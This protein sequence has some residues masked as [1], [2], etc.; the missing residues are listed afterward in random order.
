MNKIL[1]LALVIPFFLAIA[2][3]SSPRKISEGGDPELDA[4]ARQALQQLFSSEP[5][6]RDIIWPNARAVVV[7]PEAVRAGLIAGGHGGDGVMF[8]RNGKVLGYFRVTGVSFGLQAG[9]QQYSEA[10]FLMTDTAMQELTSGAG[11]SLGVGP[12]FVLVDQGVARNLTTTT[13]KADVYA[14]VFGQQG[15]MAGIGLQGQRIIRFED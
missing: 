5:K 12:T 7:F 6:G 1:R 4:Q 15:L 14:F 11:L 10:L 2:A 13:L 3:C 8:D 9:A